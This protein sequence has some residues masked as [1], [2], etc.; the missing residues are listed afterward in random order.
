[1]ET[2]KYK[3]QHVEPD[4]YAHWWRNSPIV[5]VDSKG[6]TK[7]KA[8]AGLWCDHFWKPRELV[9]WI[10]E[11]VRRLPNIRIDIPVQYVT[12]YWPCLR[13]QSCPNTRGKLLLPS[14]PESWI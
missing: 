4:W 14:L 2:R 1:M 8:H 3:L 9:I 7:A 12:F 6:K 5:D 10:Y 11:S 13:T